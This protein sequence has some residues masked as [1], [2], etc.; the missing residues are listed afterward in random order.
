VYGFKEID[1][2]TLQQ[3]QDLGKGF[4][5]LDVRTPSE[6]V[7]GV[8]GGASLLPLHLLPL[9][10]GE[11]ASDEPLVIYCRTGARSGQACAFLAQ[12][13]LTEVYNLRGGIMGWLQSGL[14]LEYPEHVAAQARA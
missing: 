2:A 9:R 6:T 10:M 3:W 1:V 5:L 13:G 14:S 7:H 12:H 4:R 8:I 11:L